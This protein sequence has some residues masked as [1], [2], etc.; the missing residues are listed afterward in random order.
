MAQGSCSVGGR[1]FPCLC[2]HAHHLLVTRRPCSSRLHIYNQGRKDEKVKGCCRH[3]LL[4]AGKKMHFRTNTSYV[5]L[6]TKGDIASSPWKEGRNLSSHLLYKK[7]F[8]QMLTV[9]M[10]PGHWLVRENGKM[11][12]RKG[13]SI[14][15]VKLGEVW[16][17]VCMEYRLKRQLVVRL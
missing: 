9:K 11:L 3:Y 8:V 13:L 6:K 7:V 5:L 14:R 1:L 12:E 15:M 17:Q 16:I 4:L 10:L 2:S